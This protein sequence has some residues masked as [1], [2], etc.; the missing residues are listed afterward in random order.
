MCVSIR[1]RTMSL[2]MREQMNVDRL[3]KMSDRDKAMKVKA[4]H[5]KIMDNDK[6]AAPPTNDTGS[7]AETGSRLSEWHPSLN[8][9]FISHHTNIAGY[10]E[11]P[12]LGITASS[13]AQ[14]NSSACRPSPVKSL[15]CMSM[16]RPLGSKAVPFGQPPKK[17]K[18]RK[19][20]HKK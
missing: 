16:S 6:S 18:G 2:A 3:Q 7:D 4:Y 12:R 20:S 15:S 11:T 5:K 13:Q 19:K 9:T 10:S 17:R 8:S 14:M 1:Y